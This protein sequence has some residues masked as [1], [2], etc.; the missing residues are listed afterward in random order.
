MFRLVP[1]LLLAA[2]P[3][4]A[5]RAFPF[6]WDTATVATDAHEMQSWVTPRL[7]RTDTGY[8]QNDLRFQA[9]GGVTSRVD[10]MFGVDV[11]LISFGTDS[12]DV[13]PRVSST[14]R[15][16][17]LRATDVLG[18]AVMGRIGLGLDLAE[19]E[20]RIVL[21]K[22]LGPLLLAFNLSGSRARLWR[23]RTGIDTRFEQTLSAR[24]QVQ[25]EFSAGVE[26]VAREAL[27]S[28]LYQGT[29][30]S[31]GPTFTYASRR[32]WLALGLLVQ[33]GADKAL[34]DRGNGEPLEL[35]DNERF[36]GRLI[37]GV[38]TD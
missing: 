20:M 12:R 3:A 15:Y 36:T 1:V 16:S 2:M 6:S 17:L 30:L 33:M 7:G 25:S 23:G 32:W 5:Q 34:A 8:L 11:D 10:T 37:L 38:T 26:V 31:V 4:R 13:Q 29:A 28:S 14:W 27:Q 22:Q 18:V 19:L 24:Y 9:V 21:D 35:R